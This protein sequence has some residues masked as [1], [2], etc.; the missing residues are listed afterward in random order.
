[1]PVALAPETLQTALGGV[2][3]SVNMLYSQLLS[4]FCC[5]SWVFGTPFRFDTTRRQV[6]DN[7]TDLVQWD[8]DSVFVNGKR[9]LLFNAEFHAYRLPVPSLWLDI[10]QKLKAAGFS[11]V[12]Y[13]TE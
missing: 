5:I 13:Y 9:I 4:A 3:A 10:F 11:G 6:S 8:K 12:S 2:P 1:M 7:L